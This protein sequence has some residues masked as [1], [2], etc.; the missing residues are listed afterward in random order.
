MRVAADAADADPFTLQI[1]R[2]LDIATRDQGLGHDVF[3]AAG[4]NHVSRSFYVSGDVADT[5]GD[6][7]FSVA[8]KQRCGDDARRRDKDQIE[9]DDCIS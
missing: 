7:H 2:L 9:V 1:L 5:A 4:E 6:G 8:A 3:H